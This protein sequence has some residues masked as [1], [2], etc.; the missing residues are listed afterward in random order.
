MRERL[1]K[2]LA[3][4]G[5][6]SRRR[7]EEMIARGDVLVNGQVA[8][9]GDSADPITDLIVVA[10]R[11]LERAAGH[12]YLALNKPRG[13]VTSAR[14]THGERTVF[15][16]IETRIRVFPVGRLDKDTS[17]LLLL[18]ND[19]DWANI[20]THPRYGVE[21][22]YR[23]LV[24]GKPSET[25]LHRL[26]EGVVL[27]DGDKTAPS[28]VRRIEARGTGTVLGI[29]VIQG[30]KRQIRL[31]A[32]AVGH[33]VIDLVR[34]RVGPVELGDLPAGRSRPLQP[35]E[36]EMMRAYGQRS[37]AASRA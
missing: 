8:R 17:G 23:A 12:E 26:R 9:L 19:G 30:K 31:M 5:V 13:Y 37:P 32:E 11:P 33:P 14:S 36:V 22:E 25:V 4:A 18:T 24:R 20:V 29:T 10:G 21:K 35:D 27:A 7:A 1:Q 3:A 2:V 34:V 28:R 16:L 6:T 15:E